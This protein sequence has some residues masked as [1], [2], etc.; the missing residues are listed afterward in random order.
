MMIEAEE[1]LGNQ[2]GARER[3]AEGLEACGMD[4]I[5]VRR[6]RTEVRS[7]DVTMPA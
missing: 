4:E 3:M 2:I 7:F 6:L 5:L 1:G